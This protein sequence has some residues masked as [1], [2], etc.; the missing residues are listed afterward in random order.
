MRRYL[1]IVLLALVL[2]SVLK[3]RNPL[4][5]YEPTGYVRKANELIAARKIRFNA[6]TGRIETEFSDRDE[7]FWYLNSYLSRDV[8]AFN[9]LCADVQA[10]QPTRLPP[11]CAAF[12]D[13]FMFEGTDL[14]RVSK[15]AHVTAI[16]GVE[17]ARWHG[18]LRFAPEPHAGTLQ[19]ERQTVSLVPMTRVVPAREFTEVPIGGPA[20]SFRP[21]VGSFRFPVRGSP[22]THAGADV[23]AIGRHAVFRDRRAPGD[24]F[25]ILIM[26]R[27]LPP[28]RIIRLEPGDWLHFRSPGPAGR[29]DG[30]T[31]VYS[32]LDLARLI[33]WTVHRNNRHERVTRP[34]SLGFSDAFVSAMNGLFN[35][36]GDRGRLNV[37]LSLRMGLQE[38]LSTRLDGFMQDHFSK[39]SLER[40]G[41]WDRP[42]R[43]A[44]VVVDAFSGAVLA[45]PT[46]PNDKALDA[47]TGITPVERRRL[48]ENQNFPL[49]PVGSAAKPFLTAAI[50]NRYPFMAGFTVAA[51]G[52]EQHETAGGWSLPRSFEDR[53]HGRLALDDYLKVSCNKYFVDF[54]TVALGV[55]DATA[56]RPRI[57]RLA[58]AL[59]FEEKPLRTE[60][61][62]AICG[63]MASRVPAIPYLGAR[64]LEKVHEN[65]IFGDLERLAHIDT[66]AYRAAEEAAPGRKLA[67][68][69]TLLAVYRS[70]RFLLPVWGS[71]PLKLNPRGQE[72]R[73]SVRLRLG[74]VSPERVNLGVNRL[75]SLRSD[76]V[77]MLLGGSTGLWNNVQLAEA[78]SRLVTGRE[79]EA[80][81]VESIDGKPEVPRAGPIDGY[82]ESARRPVLL[83]LAKAVTETGGTA[84]SHVSALRR[85]IHEEFG[86]RGFDVFLFGKTG[87]A[88]VEVFAP[89]DLGRVAHDLYANRGLEFDGRRV[90][91]TTEGR[92]R[93][94]GEHAAAI[95][96]LLTDM[97]D[98]L[99]EYTLG[100]NYTQK[101]ALFVIDGGRLKVNPLARPNRN[102]LRTK[103]AVFVLTVL[104]TPASRT[105]HP[106]ELPECLPAETVRQLRT[107]PP[108]N[109]LDPKESVGLTV[110]AYIE[111]TDKVAGE[112]AARFVN[113]MRGELRELLN[114]RLASLPAAR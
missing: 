58:D 35:E 17:V 92:R 12:A 27:E 71:L 50:L 15:S 80:R 11:P 61:K 25:G 9:T 47:F 91:L 106:A 73:L 24:E 67:A 53:A 7:Q 16:P 32:D 76:W 43:A 29:A 113:E 14:V 109:E 101:N 66:F 51:H 83:G 37:D 74:A 81:F 38:A 95:T 26:G 60:D 22:Q 99:A 102:V 72:D 70:A 100:P 2:I 114:V 46:Y 90:G 42:R 86:R 33:S 110:A 1:L 112:V 69:D 78:M 18:D 79:V 111:D 49:H 39:D 4:A 105:R 23:W 97:N 107:L 44:A 5:I 21:E 82:R 87:S 57:E 94:P 56:G 41:V 30:N 103:G 52:D 108:A 104:L 77:S 98:D 65:R 28:G 40:F 89:N 20:R 59:A 64:G 96:A 10:L 85:E 84:T 75:S 63:Q 8:D 45:L 88:T 13:R 19:G 48:L 3:A 93:L 62:F 36:L 54:A 6:E 68:G 31:Y 34:T 55:D